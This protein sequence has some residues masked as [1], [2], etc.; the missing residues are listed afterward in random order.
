ML[1]IRKWS[2]GEAELRAR[3]RLAMR[4][5]SLKRA[6]RARKSANEKRMMSWLCVGAMATERKR[7]PST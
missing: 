5:A 1:A 3:A 2:E 6:M 4:K 7:Q